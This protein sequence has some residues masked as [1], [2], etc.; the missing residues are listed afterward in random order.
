MQFAVHEDR[1]IGWRGRFVPVDGSRILVRQGD[2]A[3][4]LLCADDARVRAAAMDGNDPG[5]EI[6]C[7][8]FGELVLRICRCCRHICHDTHRVS[9]CGGRSSF[10]RV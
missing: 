5:E 9:V 3:E 8:R 10:R 7:V 2:D 4:D 6:G 1:L